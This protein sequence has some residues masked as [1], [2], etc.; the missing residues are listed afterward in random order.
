L[1][2]STAAE[3]VNVPEL[4]GTALLTHDRCDH[5]DEEVEEPIRD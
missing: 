5:N 1:M 3:S 4:F 2:W